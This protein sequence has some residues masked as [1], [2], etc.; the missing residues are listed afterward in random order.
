MLRPYEAWHGRSML[1]PYEPH[2][3]AQKRTLLSV[4]PYGRAGVG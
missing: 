3:Q 2:A 1:R 4:S